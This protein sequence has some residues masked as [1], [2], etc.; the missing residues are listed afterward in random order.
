[1]AEP[2]KLAERAF[3]DIPA[4]RIV[5]KER[6]CCNQTPTSLIND[7]GKAC[8]E[9]GHGCLWN[10][11]NH[12]TRDVVRI[13]MKSCYPASSQG[14]GETRAV[15]TGLCAWLLMSLSL[16]TLLWA[17]PRSGIGSLQPT[18]TQLSLHGS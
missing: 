16:K 7:V 17:L 8:V 9:H 1:M 6:N 4:A 12:D 13:Y 11:M 18:A 14:L 15:L 2:H 10:S 3:G 5:T